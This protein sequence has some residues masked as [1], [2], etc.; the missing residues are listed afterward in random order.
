MIVLVLI[1][2]EDFFW[3]IADQQQKTLPGQN[4]IDIG[5]KARLIPIPLRLTNRSVKPERSCLQL[6][7]WVVCSAYFTLD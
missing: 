6:K 2:E 5:L 1:L 3:K 4:G 7:L